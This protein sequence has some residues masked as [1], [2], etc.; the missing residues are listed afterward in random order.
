MWPFTYVKN[1]IIREASKDAFRKA[2]ADLE[3]TNEYNTEERAKVLMEERLTKLL[4]VVDP[5]MIVTYDSK[6]RNIYIGGELADAG[7]LNNLKAEAEFFAQ[8][9]LWRIIKETPKELAQRAMFVGGESLDDMKKG[10]AM[11]FTLDTQQKILETFKGYAQA[12]PID[13]R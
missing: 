9:E 2:L 7:R 3:E 10:K 11:L 1:W 6:N 13:S 5:H 12:K 8:S 4:S